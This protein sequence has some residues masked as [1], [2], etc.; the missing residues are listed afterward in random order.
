VAAVGLLI[1]GAIWHIG[2]VIAQAVSKDSTQP[3]RFG[4]WLMILGGVMFIISL[5]KS[6]GR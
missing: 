4:M 1:V 6:R 2:G 3:G 5:I